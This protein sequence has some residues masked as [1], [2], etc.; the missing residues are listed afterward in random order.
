M[1]ILFGVILIIFAVIL[2][3]YAY[4][5][6]FKSVEVREATVEPIEFAYS[7]HR[8]AYEK[9]FESWEAFE[10]K[11][12]AAGLGPCDALAVYLDPPETPKENL[13]S[14]LGC[15]IDGLTAEAADK[16]RA[17]FPSFVTPE[18]PALRAQFPYKNL[19]S[20]F[21]AP[22]K[23]YPKMQAAMKDKDLVAPIAMEIYGV[24]GANE[25][26]RFVMPI[27]SDVEAFQPLFDAFNASSSDAPAAD[28]SGTE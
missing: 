26:I 12:E 2:G 14:V 15:R 8:G 25:D 10:D 24:D 1:R 9:L 13:R 21:F 20:Y 7:T 3:G 6:G 11:W 18:G 28:A 17:A 27:R 23:V 19:A 4:M 16:W 5:G 22:V